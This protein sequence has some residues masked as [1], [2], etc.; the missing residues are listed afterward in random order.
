MQSV[1]KH[2]AKGWTGTLLDRVRSGREIL[3]TRQGKSAARLIPVIAGFDR[4]KA[5]RAAEGLRT[6]SKGQTPGGLSSRSLRVKVGGELTPAS[7]IR[8]LTHRQ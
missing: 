2:D 6:A 5:R 1:S 3:I 8:Q 7:S 4:A